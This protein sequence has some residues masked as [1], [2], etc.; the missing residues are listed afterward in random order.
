MSAPDFSPSKRRIADLVARSA[1]RFPALER[2]IAFGCRQPGLVK[3]GLG[4]VAHGYSRV[5]RGR[6]LR[7]AALD[8]YRLWVNVAEPLGIEPFF[9]GQSGASWLTSSLISEGDNC[10]DAGANVGHYTFLMASI[11]GKRGHVS[12]FE[13]NPEMVELLRRSVTL[14]GHDSFV[15]IVPR[16]LWN[17]AGVEMTF[18]LSTDP[19]NTGTSSLLQQG[20]VETSDHTIRVTTTTLDDFARERA[21]ERLRLVKLDV[22]RAEE[23]VLRGAARLLQGAKVDYLIVELVRGTEAERV[24]ERHGY[25]GYLLAGPE[26][27]L[28]PLARVPQGTFCDVLFV[29][30]LVRAEFEQKFSHLI[31]RPAAL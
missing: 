10:V 25:S 15:E 28:K 29:S 14:N 16:A 3:L 18:F 13:A 1:L 22:E 26:L 12:A 27:P 2:A 4:A 8:N 17:E 20:G 7:V 31:E 6:E 30:P 9:F 11:V 24:L 21:F 23:Q 19:A 5:L